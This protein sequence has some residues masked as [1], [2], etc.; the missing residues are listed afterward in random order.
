MRAIFCAVML[1]VVLA[2]SFVIGA[3]HVIAGETWPDLS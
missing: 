3:V 2:G 1:F